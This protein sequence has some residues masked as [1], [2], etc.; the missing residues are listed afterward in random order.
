ME[1]NLQFYITCG[2][3]FLLIIMSIYII[4]AKNKTALHYN[5][6][7]VLIQ[8]VIWSITVMMKGIFNST[9]AQMI[10]WENATY[11][12]VATVPVG[13]FILAKSYAQ[14]GRGFTKK[15]LFALS[16]TDHNNID[17][18]DKLESLVVFQR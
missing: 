5:F 14:S 17:Y 2:T 6:L 13:V 3:V 12:G 1:L 10:F 15:I 16:H 4:L 9:N 11:F 8:V 7:M 18:M